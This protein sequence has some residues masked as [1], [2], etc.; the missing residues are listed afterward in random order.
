[1]SIPEQPQTPANV[2]VDSLNPQSRQLNLTVKVVKKGEARE[3]VSRSD[4]SSHKVV[5]AL[6]GDET[7]AIYMTL[8]D[9]NIEKVKD[10]DI[11]DVKN[12]Y[13]SLFKG[14]MRLNI[15]RFGS[16]EASQA[17]IAEV[18]DK[19]NLSDKTFEQE[20]RPYPSFR[21]RYGDEGGYRGG[22]RG[23]GSGGGGFRGGRRRRF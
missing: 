7:G 1:M 14:S 13:V 22:G 3:T 21:P 18:N 6:V 9:D 2:K 12:G 20:R 5:D 4:G 10:G 8:W 11:I 17:A 15:G 19:N 23:G 16:F